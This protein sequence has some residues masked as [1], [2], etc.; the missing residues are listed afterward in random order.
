M[1]DD[2]TGESLMQRSDDT[3]QAL[4]KR[5]KGYHD[6]T[7]PILERYNKVCHRV[8]ANQG[9]DAVWK[10]LDAVISPIRYEMLGKVKVRELSSGKWQM[11]NGAILSTDD[12]KAKVS[13][14]ARPRRPSLPPTKDA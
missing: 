6:E 2:Q 1:K 3:A 14:E 5:L 12:V 13:A 11:A 7:E 10:E 9:M 4:V 8:N